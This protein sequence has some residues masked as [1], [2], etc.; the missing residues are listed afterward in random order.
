M[1]NKD[2]VGNLCDKQRNLFYD[3]TAILLKDKTY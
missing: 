2:I 3:K 1:A